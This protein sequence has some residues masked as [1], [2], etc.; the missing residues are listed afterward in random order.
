ML[1]VT[2]SDRTR[3]TEEAGVL[4]VPQECAAKRGR[5][6]LCE[7]IPRAI[8][9]RRG[10]VRLIP[11]GGVSA[12]PP[13][14]RGSRGPGSRGRQSKPVV[15]VGKF[16]RRLSCAHAA[17]HSFFIVPPARERPPWGHPSLSSKKRGEIRPRSAE[18]RRLSPSATKWPRLARESPPPSPPPPLAP[19]PG[20]GT[21]P[22]P[23]RRRDGAG[24]RARGRRRPRRLRIYRRAKKESRAPPP[25]PPHPLLVL[26][27]GPPSL[28]RPTRV[29]KPRCGE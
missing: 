15:D 10:R 24:G 20:P 17:S 23:P 26:A 21:S 2:P 1:S 5:L 27:Q 9:E 18:S 28:T 4:R 6:R 29:G 22:T 8:C 11:P 19:R 25:S 16:F 12:Y 3:Q 13:S 7:L 14:R